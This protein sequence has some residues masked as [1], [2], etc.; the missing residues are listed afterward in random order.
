MKKQKERKKELNR[1]KTI[2][3]GKSVKIKKEGSV[4]RK[5]IKT[6]EIKNK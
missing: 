3:E 4:G 5:K 2:K 6:E 1:R